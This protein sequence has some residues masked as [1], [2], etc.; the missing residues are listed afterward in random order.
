M[1]KIPSRPVPFSIFGPSVFVFVEKSGNGTETGE[2]LFRP[3]FAG[4]R[5]LPDLIHI[6]PVFK[7]S[8]MS[9]ICISAQTKAS[10]S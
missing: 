2:G 8:G 10:Y 6:Y 1:E 9:P 3:F 7:K 4:S 5:F